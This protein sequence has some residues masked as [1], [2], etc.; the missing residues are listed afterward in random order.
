[1]T[2][3]FKKHKLS[4]AEKIWLQEVYTTVEF[5]LKIAKVKLRNKLPKDFDPKK[6]D[7]RLLFEGKNLTPI[8][9]WHIDK[10]SELLKNI[11]TVI[12]AIKDLI[13]KK[14][15]IENIS[16]KQISIITKIEE[17][18][19]GIAL[20]DM[21]YLGHFFYS[22]SSPADVKGYSSITLSSDDAYD[23]YLKYE[24]LE[25]LMEEYYKKYE[26]SQTSTV[27]ASWASTPFIHS[28]QNWED[29]A[30]LS[31]RTITQNIKPHTVF[32]LMAINP[33]IP[34]LED[35]YH[36]IKDVCNNFK[37]IANRADEIEHQDRITDLILSEIKSCE[38]LIADLSYERPNV[39][40]EIGYA[41]AH[42][43]K[44]ILIRKKGTKLHFD[45]S[46][47]NAPEYK[48]ITKLR[49]LLT[50]RFEAILGRSAE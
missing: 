23:E 16:A 30:N 32:V 11:E 22:V 46:I 15:G 4:E 20:W 12:L 37:L 36:T 31:P 27:T 24:N 42:N 26:V 35:V 2:Y 19:V 25:N 38:F 44:P 28:F 43:K 47:H 14:P 5:D 17:S 45:L 39:Y 29:N 49:E 18:K 48:N 41:H 9:V 13:I 33:D 6:I 10:N 40:Y 8:G 1:M 7:K 21:N 34:E 3:Y 50:K